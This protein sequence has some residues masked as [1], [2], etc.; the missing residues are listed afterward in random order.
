MD[1]E[2]AK[3]WERRRN[4]DDRRP[5]PEAEEE[6]WG[7]DDR[8][9]RRR[10]GRRLDELSPEEKDARA[11]RR[12]RTVALVLLIGWLIVS[13]IDAVTLRTAIGYAIDP[14]PKG[15][16]RWN[17]LGEILLWASAVVAAICVFGIVSAVRMRRL[18]GYWMAAAS[19]M[20]LL[21]L[22]FPFGIVCPGLWIA[23]AFALFNL[24]DRRIQR[25]F[26]LAREGKAGF[27]A[28]AKPGASDR[29]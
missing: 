10:R 2:A 1:D 18:R 26:R 5:P 9:R 3:P 20:A 6:E 11:R 21:L 29:W 27:P 22:S 24:G 7:P 8:P 25:V 12:V 19:T 15:M 23:P 17:E 14:A 4:P 13:A 28:R 16:W